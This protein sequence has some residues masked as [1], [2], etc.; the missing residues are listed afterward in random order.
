MSPWPD[1]SVVLRT[2]AG[3]AAA[4]LMFVTIPYT[5]HAVGETLAVRL[6]ETDGT[7]SW[8]ADSAAGH[9]S[10]PSNQV[11]RTNDNITYT[12]E[13]SSSN[14][15]ADNATIAMTLPRGVQFDGLP[16]FCTGSGSALTPATMPSPAVPV[17][18]TSW[19]TLP[20]QHL[21]CNIGTLGQG[22]TRSYDLVARVRP[23]VPN[24]TPL[25]GNTASISSTGAPVPVVS[26]PVADIVVSARAQYDL[27]TNGIATVTNSGWQWQGLIPCLKSTGL[28]FQLRF[29]MTV[30]GP[31]G[32]K[33]V[34]PLDG[35]VTWTDDLSPVALFG[36]SVATNPAYIAAG[37]AA[38]STYG[39]RLLGCSDASYLLPGP[40]GAAT[41]LVTNVRDNGTT[42]CTQPGGYGTPVQVAVTKADWSAYTYPSQVPS[43][44]G[45][46][47]PADRA[48]VYSQ[49][50]WFEIPTTTPVDLG[51]AS[52]SSYSLPLT[53]TLTGFTA[54]DIGGGTNTAD[55]ATDDYRTT[56][57]P[58]SSTGGLSNYF[59]GVPGAAGNTSPSVFSPGWQIYEGPAGSTGTETGDGQ[60]FAGGKTIS[61]LFFS[62]N[63]TNGAPV[64]ILGCDAWDNTKLQLTNMTTAATTL[65]AQKYQAA[66]V[67]VWLSGWFNDSNTQIAPT[68][69]QVE[70]GTGAGGSGVASRC[71]DSSSPDGWFS[72][73]ALVPGNDPALLAQG[74][75]SAV[76]RVRVN[77]TVP[78][79]N[80]K[81][82]AQV[83]IGLR[84]VDGLVTGTVLPNW[85]SGRVATN[86]SNTLAVMAAS[87][88]SWNDS[89]YNPSTNGGNLGDRL[90][91]ASAVGRVKKEVWDR[92][93]AGWTTTAVPQYTGGQ[94]VDF[95]LSPTLTSGIGATATR[96]VVV[97]DCIPAGLNFS[98][99][100][101]A[102]S[103]VEV[104]TGAM[105]PGANLTCTAAQTYV[106]WDL[107][108]RTVNQVITPITYTVRLSPS[109]QPGTF[110]NTA[111]VTAQEDISPAA[112]RT[113]TSSVQLV[114]PRGVAI[115]K[116]ALTPYVDVNRPGEAI[117]AP[118]RWRVDM[119]NTE[120]ATLVPTDVDIIDALPQ[121][122]VGA[123]HFTG[124]LTLTGVTVL[125]G[126]TNSQPVQ[127]LYTGAASVNPYPS[128][129]TNDVI[130]GIPWCDAS[131]TLVLGAGACPADLAHATGV[132]VRRP[133]AFASTDVVSFEVDMVPTSN[134]KGDVYVNQAAGRATGLSL[135]VGPIE[136]PA[137]VQASSIGDL[138]WSDTNG[139]GV[140][141]AGEA[142]IAGFPVGLTGTDSDGNAVSMGTTTDASGAYVFGGLP[143]GS[144]T[145]TFD[146]AHLAALGP[147][148]VFT[149]RHVGA[150]TQRDSTADATTG[151]TGPI[152]LPAAV[153]DLSIDQGVRLRPVSVGDRVWR[154][155]NRNGIQDVGE[156]GV[157]GVQVTMKDGSGAV[158]ATTT[159]ASGGAYAFTDLFATRTYT[160]TFTAPSGSTWT[161]PHA[162][163]ST[164]TTDSDVTAGA[165]TLTAPTTGA[166]SAA[167]ADDA[168]I[169]AGL[170]AYNLTLDAAL[171][172][173]S[174]YRPGQ[175]LTFVLTPHNAGPSAVLPGWSVT[176]LLPAGLT[177]VSIVGSTPA[178]SCDLATLTCANAQTLAP[179][180]DAGTITVTATVDPFPA[181]TSVTAV[182]HVTPAAADV[183]ES[184]S[185]DNSA[186]VAVPLTPYVSVGDR[187]TYDVNRDG[188]EGPGDLP[189][190]A[191]TVEL[192]VGASVS[193]R[194]RVT[195]TDADGFYAFTGLEPSTA[196]TVRFVL[197][198]GDALA[199]PTGGTTTVT[200][201]AS[202]ANSG[203]PGLADSAGIDASIVR[204]D[205]ALA[206]S[207]DT[208]G[209][210]LPGQTVTY[211][212]VP[213]NLGP[214]AA[215]AGWSVTDLL[216]PGL[217]LVSMSGAGYDCT[218][219]GTCVAS[220][221]L[222][223]GATGG[224]IT[225]T[226]QLA[227]V[228]LGLYHATAYVSPAASDAPEIT[229]LLVPLST[230]DTSATSTN[231]DAQ[232]SLTVTPVSIGD[233]V[234]LDINRDSVD[235]ASEPGVVGVQVTLYE[236]DGT[237]VV[238]TT[239]T[240]GSGHFV[241]DG[242]QPSTTYDV[243]FTLPLG[244]TFA[245]QKADSRPNETTGRVT[246]TTP[247][248]GRNLS[249]LGLADDGTVNA[250]LLSTTDLT[251]TKSLLTVGAVLP[252]GTLTFALTPR[253]LGTVGALAGWS[254]TE[255][256]PEGLQLVSMSGPGYVC[257]LGTATC[258]ATYVLLPGAEAAPV[259]V[260]ATLVSGQPQRNVAY[261][262]PASGDVAET[263]ALEVPGAGADT[264]VTETDNDAS[265][266]VVPGTVVLA[267]T[268]TTVPLWALLL[269]VG[270]LVVGV[271]VLL[272]A[273]R[274]RTR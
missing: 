27:S 208:A 186:S 17:T 20:Q 171:T 83:S 97:E 178:W 73:P 5:G 14:G 51:T 86:A 241:F 161:T 179:G 71:N 115:D 67:P 70:Y 23:E 203:T 210:Y 127:V 120:A 224:P 11:V 199:S 155:V 214:T 138:V 207:L 113:A 251:L 96:D 130:S 103:L 156:P 10:G 132:R 119:T 38:A 63:S 265:V 151:G 209:P 183:V 1:T 272:V 153:D 145:V 147:Q 137:T 125:S 212:L 262:A 219:P 68:N 53:N 174:P 3:V 253:N 95:R 32:G 188:A 150:D 49:V 172:T 269:G 39:G 133:G 182:A 167:T 92:V 78:S 77:L 228:A 134:A 158:V 201:P 117:P 61:L 252:G 50:V 131:G 35:T 122:G 136:A 195:T 205:L 175:A 260:T 109:A 22:A 245:P 257:D 42:A 246:V 254:V 74:I 40:G 166:N 43:P 215:F 154:D 59:V 234:W 87:A 250:G 37:A 28:C 198:P 46:A 259:I 231:N 6:S 13:V 168:S 189:Y 140:Q 60:L 200:T 232:Q 80:G 99:A 268:G 85:A 226:A 176:D 229:P 36:A 165:A 223:S 126:S 230:T 163:G 240:D 124:S 191:M 75:Y 107:G 45:T 129:P 233:R 239:A 227:G 25:V 146:P 255:V 173:P 8:D 41:N 100:T 81:E 31:V 238:A 44:I 112:K 62:N 72:D 169:D 244:A 152:S 143:T 47:L 29:P 160:L 194:P 270:A 116:V 267:V 148:Y 261:V 128:D 184:M 84:A 218:T 108:A 141:D 236:A 206:M 33:G 110:T 7:P 102:P 91:V 26:A 263:S 16:A 90:T 114:Q 248:S 243:E 247:A 48:F 76:S 106:R 192:Y 52:G 19:T 271:V 221:H 64:T 2:L 264:A 258:T 89:S 180:G 149:T 18:A 185:T 190:A 177:A 266:E 56:S 55:P 21:S 66:N 79:A 164:P 193:G 217:T 105:P 30:A 111:L 197:S 12:V 82:W 170:V 213:S 58:V 274:R 216:P 187:V 220:A 121:N 157:D 242:L 222:A 196:Y 24:G 88:L 54:T 94:S 237:T 69:F 142:G 98:S 34:S 225:V 9:D 93:N 181:A 15:A 104:I 65:A 123:T 4:C 249:A 101:T 139:N 235:D 204:Y 162:A 57:L 202:G 159:T 144:Y 211:T 135:D 118:L 273:S 256:L